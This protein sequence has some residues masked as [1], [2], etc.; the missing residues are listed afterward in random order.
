LHCLLG[1]AQGV[2]LR[3]IASVDV[4]TNKLKEKG[5]LGG[6]IGTREARNRFLLLGGT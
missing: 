2:S 3:G 4:A 1:E 6:G 5:L